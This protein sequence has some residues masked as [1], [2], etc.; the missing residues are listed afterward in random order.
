MS[1]TLAIT[2]IAIIFYFLYIVVLEKY[3]GKVIVGYAESGSRHWFYPIAA[4]E[5]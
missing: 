1:S 4:R 2:M 3:S 5:T